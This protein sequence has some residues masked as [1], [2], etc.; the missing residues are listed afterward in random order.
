[1]PKLNPI[2]SAIKKDKVHFD[3]KEEATKVGFKEYNINEIKV[4]YNPRK[5]FDPKE[6]QSLADSIQENGLLQ[7]I[8]IDNDLN[9]VAG[10]RRLRACKMLGY[11]K[12]PAVKYKGDPKKK[13]AMSILENIQ[14]EDITF[15]EFGKG[16][17]ELIEEGYK[18]VEIAKLLG[19]T[20]SWISEALSGYKKL[21]ELGRE[22]EKISAYSLRE[23]LK[24]QTEEENAKKFGTTN[25]SDEG[26]NGAGN[27]K[28]G[29]PSNGNGPKQL[30]LFDYKAFAKSIKKTKYVIKGNT[31]SITIKDKETLE[32]IKTMLEN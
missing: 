14:R 12:I 10:E 17:L 3:L 5:N 9:L 16:C 20:K 8:V 2:E 1:M 32:K 31:I 4:I 11:L 22:N 27:K 25:F 28:S 21:K 26:K 6:M 7:P 29:T 19:K 30:E 13:K 23:I 18:Q 24:T 15:A